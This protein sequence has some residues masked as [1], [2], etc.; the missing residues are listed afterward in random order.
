MSHARCSRLNLIPLPPP[1]STPSLLYPLNGSIL[2]NPQHGVP[3]GRLAEQSPITGYEPNDPVEV[4]SAGG[5][6]NALTIEWSKFWFDL[7]LLR[8]HRWYPCIIGSG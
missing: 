7:Q 3:F 4:S 1:H 2:R 5:Y 6:D 8:G